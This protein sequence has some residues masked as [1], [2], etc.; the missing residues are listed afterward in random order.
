M[1]MK[2]DA[3]FSHT[4]SGGGDD[5]TG[6]CVYNR[7]IGFC[8][9]DEIGG[10]AFCC[11]H[12]DTND[13]LHL[14]RGAKLSVICTK[15]VKKVIHFFM[16]IFCL[17]IQQPTNIRICCSCG[18]EMTRTRALDI[19]NKPTRSTLKRGFKVHVHN[20]L[21]NERCASVCTFFSQ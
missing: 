18:D 13:E 7:D 3:I 15:I 8:T 1:S 17:N 10:L 21:V 14:V 19:K 2:I 4:L 5:S 16:S 20:L 11:W 9:D 12:R 6:C